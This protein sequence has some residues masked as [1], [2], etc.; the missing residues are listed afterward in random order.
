MIIADTNL[1]AYLLIDGD[2]TPAA[3][4]VWLRDPEWR[5][6]PLWRA[7]FLN[8]LWVS[9]RAGVLDE[10]KALTAWRRATALF[11]K[12]EI[13]PG[14]EEVLTAA[15]RD[16]LSADDAHFVVLAE[17]LGVKLV[18]SDKVLL[19]ARPDLAV[20]MQQFVE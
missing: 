7:K 4:A 20:G 17:R 19:K 16:G 5:M 8:V 1:I 9:V 13:E 3:R 12:A 14:G 6:P 15:V 2:F 11:P 10:A 18:T